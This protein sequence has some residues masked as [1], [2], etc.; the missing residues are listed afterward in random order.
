MDTL[1]IIRMLIENGGDYKKAY[2]EAN[3]NLSIEDRKN[4]SR[5]Y[6]NLD[7]IDLYGKRIAFLSID[8]KKYNDLSSLGINNF[9]KYIRLLQEIDGI[10]LAFGVV[11]QGSKSKVKI[12]FMK[13]DSSKLSSLDLDE[14][15]SKFG[16]IKNSILFAEC[17][18]SLP[19]GKGLASLINNILEELKR[20]I[21]PLESLGEI[22][23]ASIDRRLKE[24]FVSTNFLSKDIKTE[25]IRK[26]MSFVND[27][28]N[29]SVIYSNKI[30]LNIFLMRE[31]ELV[32]RIKPLDD[33]FAEIFIS[34]KDYNMIAARYGVDDKDIL[35]CIALFDDIDVL[36]AKISIETDHGMKKAMK[37]F[38]ENMSARRLLNSAIVAGNDMGIRAEEIKKARQT[39]FSRLKKLSSKESEITQ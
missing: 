9:E 8:K 21:K 3:S 13:P 37:T 5:I 12:Y 4:V 39:I 6:D 23:K 32:R 31:N 36:R 35:S 34:N 28:A 18:Y 25:D 16:M 14:L 17:E 7:F 20:E 15:A 22:D 29:Y 10:E 24:I 1:E 30:P 19:R 26:I 27:G 2:L 38:E 11:E 33:E